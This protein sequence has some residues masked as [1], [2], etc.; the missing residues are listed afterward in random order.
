[1]PQK[2][3]NYLRHFLFIERKVKYDYVF[4]LESEEFGKCTKSV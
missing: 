1:M 4:K 3:R 2:V